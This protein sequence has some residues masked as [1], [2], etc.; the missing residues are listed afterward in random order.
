MKKKLLI[1]FIVLVMA[2]TF[3]PISAL[4][5]PEYSDVNGHWAKS[6]ITEWS[7]LGIIQGS[8][9]MFRPDDSI[10]RGEMAIIIDRVM[11]YQTKANNSFSDLGQAYYTDAILKANA[12]GVILGGGNLVRPK[13]TITREEAVV[14]LGRALGVNENTQAGNNFSD[15]KN[16]S[17]WAKGYVNTMSKLGYVQ[18][19]NGKFNPA[20]SITR[21]EVVTIMNNAIAELCNE[22]KEYTGDIS[23]TVIVNT[24]DVVLN[25]MAINGDLIIA[26]GVGS[27]DVT[28]KDVTVSGNTIVRGGGANSIH[29]EG[30]SQ[31]DNLIIEKTDDGSI[32]IVT[33]DG[34][35]IK[36]TVIEDGNDDIILTGSFESVT[37]VADVNVNAVDASIESVDITDGGASFDVD[38]DSSIDEV[39]VSDKADGAEISVSGTISTLTTDA[40]ITVSNDGTIT[41]A[42]INANDVIID[43]KEPKTIEVDD[44]VTSEPTDSDGNT[45]DGTTSTGGSGGGGGSTTSSFSIS[46]SKLAKVS[47]TDGHT[48]DSEANQAA[49][50]IS[51]SGNTVTVAGALENLTA[52]AST[53]P[54]QGTHQWVGLAVDTGEASIIGVSY[55]DSA[56][57][58][59]DVDEAASV[60]V[61]A[62]SFVLWIKADEVVSTAKTFTL[63]KD[64][65]R[66][67]TVTI[68][69]KEPSATVSDVTISGTTGSAITPVDLTIT[70]SNDTF[71][72][73]IAQDDDL[74]VWF[75]NLPSGLTAAAKNAVTAG[76][77]SVTV[78]ISGTPTTTS[79][80]ALAI[81]ILAS[82]LTS[83]HDLIVT[84]NTNAK[85]AI[86]A[87][88]NNA[89]TVVSG[90]E[91]QSGSATPA[92]SSSNPAAVVYTANMSTWFEDSDSD[93]L[94]YS[95]VSA[96]DGSSNDVSADVGISTSTITYTP[97]AAQASETVTIVVKAND[98]TADSTTNVTITVTVAAQPADANNAPTVVSGQETQSG[99]A[100]PAASSS[101][102]A[103]VVYTANMSTW[104]EDSDSDPLTYSVVSAVD[105]SSNDV[106]ADVGI[107]TSTITYTPD[108]AQA[109]ETVTIVVKA[110]DGT[111]DSTTNVT[112]TVTVAAQPADANNAPTVVSGQETQSGSATPAASSSNPA[113]VVYTANMST[114]FEDSDSDPL[115]YSVVSAV[116][117]SSND[118][119]ADVG[120]S[121]ST[122][123][124]TPDAAQ[125]SETVTI[126]VKA[127]DGT[128]DSTTNVTITVTV[129]AQ[130]ADANNAPTVVS[131]QETQSG[132]ATPAASSSNPAAVVYTANMSTWF[133]DSDSDPLT[134][135]VVSAVDGSS[136]DVSAD[137]GISTSTI[138]YTPDAAQASETVT[139]VVKANDGTADST[140][141]VTITVTVAAQPAD[142]N[143]APTVVSGQETQSGSATPA[144]SSSNPAAVVYTANMSTWF[145]D[146]D[147]DP[148]TY[149]VVSAVDGSSNDVS[150]DVGISTSTIT[151]TP[152]AAQA[153]E[154]VTIVVK[155]NDG[156][157]DSTTNVTITVTVAAQ[158]ADANNAPTVVSG[159]ETQSGS[160]TPAASSSNPAAVVYTANMSTWFEDSDSDPLTY[161]VV[162]AVDGSSNDVSADVGISTS[163]ITYTPDAAQA[164]ETVTIVVKAND[165][166]ADSTTNVTITVTVA[167]QPADAPVIATSSTIANATV[168]PT[169]TVTGT[170]FNSSLSASD[171][172]I[173]VGTTGLTVSSVT[174]ISATEVTVAFT[175]TAAAGDV[176]IQASTSAFDPTGSDVSN[177]LTITVPS[178]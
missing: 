26:E 161:S 147:S 39:T 107:S 32:R 133:E 47:Q 131:G 30:N 144:A 31:I 97:D 73:D 172:T 105:G 150:A 125:A 139:I 146:S 4:A 173:G 175:G 38:E 171:F 98:G 17:S 8:D 167:A 170:S 62:G 22:A 119:S 101:N 103:A 72:S 3:L 135:S 48:E 155:A 158:P 42:V 50:T 35:V 24:S 92:A 81:T 95:V 40:Q 99:S 2:F 6:A 124:Y 77:T 153:S 112:I 21:A 162:S 159:Q 123:T 137:V 79:S 41:E 106:S 117:G 60:D 134:Y 23:G 78:T 87:D 85:Y 176:T 12:A 148:L 82:A 25:D 57:T 28:L 140:T 141:N 169:V 177:T 127:N 149:S 96:V 10:T 163:T 43:G 90:Q 29:I 86:S 88:A 113:A 151:Y 58:Q 63:S 154:T 89:P 100:T 54:S 52:F 20:S 16:I 168:D 157:A 74:S 109:S 108:A 76:G 143:N 46:V 67:T 64:G 93:P 80:E 84:S 33:S 44:S 36:A 83:N 51:Q 27:G 91:T 129:A 56:L 128:A 145:E 122:I 110:N 18:G 69:F 15:S 68:Y 114:W 14:M 75:C 166:T 121:T 152:D 13:D 126:V 55:N 165:G 1:L 174:Y 136:N 138:T 130:P 5:T 115:T 34:T 45:V 160:A 164:S 49:V 65:M 142:A 19:A 178:A 53:D 37:I 104:F 118:V 132:S 116:D 11:Q 111:A 61:G 156:T 71:V 102:P 7:D 94:T 120:I 9:G 70:L 66:D 59:T